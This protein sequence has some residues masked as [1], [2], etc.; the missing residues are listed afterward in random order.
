MSKKKK[1]LS[2]TDKLMIT[3]IIIEL[4]KMFKELF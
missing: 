2:K 1:K 3:A 4:I